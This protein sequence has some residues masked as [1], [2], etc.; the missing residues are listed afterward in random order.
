MNLAF[1][2]SKNSLKG[3]DSDLTN[4]TVS[5]KSGVSCL[6]S[7]QKVTFPYS[8]YRICLYWQ[9]ECK[10]RTSKRELNEKIHTQSF[11][12][13][14]VMVC[15]WEH[16]KVEKIVFLQE[17]K[18]SRTKWV[19]SFSC[20]FMKIAKQYQAVLFTHCRDIFLYQMWKLWIIVSVF[21]IFNSENWFCTL[22]VWS[23]SV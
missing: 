5:Q 4:K 7:D 19:L 3:P 1:L 20:N 23:C 13:V 22:C 9:N 16:L 12:P 6:L 21:S 15:L 11:M 8:T 10:W 18:K 14:F 2:V 17:K